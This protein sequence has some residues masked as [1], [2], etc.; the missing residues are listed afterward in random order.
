MHEVNDEVLAS[1]LSNAGSGVGSKAGDQ[2]VLGGSNRQS[3]MERLHPLI[4]LTFGRVREFIREPEAL[5][6]V[7]V[8]PVLLAF[9]LGIAFRNTAPEQIRVAVVGSSD[10][11]SSRLLATRLSDSPEVEAILLG[12]QDAA[13]ALRTGRVALIVRDQGSQNGRSGGQFEYSFDPTRPESRIARLTVDDALQRQL[14][15]NDIFG[16]Q[17]RV[18]SEPGS[19]YIDF[20][21][22]GLVGLNLMGSGMW[23]LGFAVVQ[24]RTRKLL[25]RLSAT[26][27]RR[28]HYLL[29]F[30]LS[31]LV[32]LFF[33]VAAVILFGWLAFSV[34]VHGSIIDLALV[35]IVGAAAFAGLGLLVASRPKTI[36]GVS[37]WMNLV[38]L[39]MWLLS[40]TFFSSARFPEVL[41]PLIK[42]LPLTAL[43]DSLR[44]VMNEG[45]ALGAIW[46]QVAVLLG[47]GLLAFGAALRLFRWQ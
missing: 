13:Q 47:W 46:F 12:P 7:F 8:F 37:G 30:M 16:A 26:P 23:G 38:M 21:I 25:K 22:P 11:E 34:S 5:F 1:G 3:Q 28:S 27:M 15:R 39:P 24:A 4:E 42:V 40:G 35:S 29:S 9:A 43:N 20:L 36:E 44:M 32:F 33:E 17:D 19:R 18:I 31:R 10:E 6:W 2:A 41:Q 45:A 14:G